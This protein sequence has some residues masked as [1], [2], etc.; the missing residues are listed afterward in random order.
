M[1]I[2]NV[3]AQIAADADDVLLPLMDL[4]DGMKS[5]LKIARVLVS[6]VS[7]TIIY[8]IFLLLAKK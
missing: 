5:S 1:N 7:A 2:P 3:K 6:F 4:L 8:T